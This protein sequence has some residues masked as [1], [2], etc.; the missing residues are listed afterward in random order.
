MAWR[1][2]LR[3]RSLAARSA[4]ARGEP[5]EAAALAAEVVAE[6]AR[7]GERRHTAL[8]GILLARARHAAGEPVDLD[9]LDAVV[10]RLDRVAGLEAW[11]LSAELAADFGVPRWRSLAADRVAAVAAGA[12]PWA[13]RLRAAA[14]TV[15]DLS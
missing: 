3:R 12:G 1:A 5:A 13:D 11:W 7:L 6:A 14:A 2:R 9:R 4:L 10:A 8:G 15:L